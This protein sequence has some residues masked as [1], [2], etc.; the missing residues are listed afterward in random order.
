MIG[1]SCAGVALAAVLLLDGCVFR[2]L[3]KD[4]ARLEGMA[5]IGGHALAGEESAPIVVILFGGTP[6]AVVDAFA[7]EGSGPYYFTVPAG[8]YRIA[9]FVDRNRD[10][11]YQPD[12]EP[13]ATYGA[14]TDVQ[15][16]AGQQVRN[17]DLRIG[18][19]VGARLDFPVS[20]AEVGAQRSKE[21][22]P[23]HLGEVVTLDDPRFSD[24][25]AKMGL[26]RPVEF[27]F[28]VGGG[29]YF[30]QP[31][32][33]GRMPV[34]FVHGAGGEPRDWRYVIEH[35]DRKKFQPWVLYYPSGLS[36]DLTGRAVARW[37]G[38]LSA[39]YGFKRLIIV[40]HSMGGL[41]SR[42]AIN[43]MVANGDG[44]MLALFVS[45]STPWRGHPAAAW[46]ASK[47]PVVMPMWTD[48][49]PGSAFLDG[50]FR[51]S[52]P[53][54][55]PYYLLFSYEGHSLLI[56]EPNDGVVPLSSE[57]ALP[58]QQ[59]ARK[60]YGFPKSHVGILDAADVSQTLN[61]LLEGAAR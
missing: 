57:L 23:I 31:F 11:V 12:T 30:L 52:L 29:F 33:S 45:L 5:M 19:T 39:R 6:P 2:G 50:I 1:R 34:L 17:L 20:V 36:V 58:A 7:L 22:P 37:L 18:P 46:G 15:V 42:A 54:G 49:A 3:R 13:A 27:L 4:V 44:D 61:S 21:L 28:D 10:L 43:R 9:A 35:L 56:D 26:W 53:S 24:E 48:V 38:M 51:T 8:T 16:G 41:V 60:V 59:A 25:N 14:P 55:C 47:A 40:A 32:D